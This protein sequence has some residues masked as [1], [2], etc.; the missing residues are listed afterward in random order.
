V[1]DLGVLRPW[2]GRGIAATLLL[3]LFA[4]FARRGY[5]KVGLGVDSQNDTGATALYEKVR[6]R[7][8][9]QFGRYEK[10]LWA[11]GSRSG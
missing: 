7:T 5:R 1:S 6:M 11:E 3:H 10:E 2:R 8:V 4:E 9:H